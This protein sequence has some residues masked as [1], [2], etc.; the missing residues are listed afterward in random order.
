[1]N[2]LVSS[3]WRK[4]D[5]TN[6]SVDKKILQKPPVKIFFFIMLYICLIVIAVIERLMNPGNEDMFA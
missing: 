3:L 4:Q 6:Y 1:M 5:L 2:E